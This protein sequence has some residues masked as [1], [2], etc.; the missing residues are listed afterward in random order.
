MP[1][2]EA[3]VS[4]FDRIA[5]FA[6]LS[7]N[8]GVASKF[9]VELAKLKKF[10][11]YLEKNQ[12]NKVLLMMDEPL[13]STDTEIVGK[14]LSDLFNLFKKYPNLVIMCVSN[15]SSLKNLKDALHMGMIVE[16]NPDGTFTPTYKWQEGPVYMSDAWYQFAKIFGPEFG[17][18]N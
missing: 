2:K 11:E 10:Q 1:A 14:T 13:T 15:T 18:C 5:I 16:K 9:Q 7:D 3:F 8:L 6:N 17:K 12:D 4:Q